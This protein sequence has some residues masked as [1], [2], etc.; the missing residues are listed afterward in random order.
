MLAELAAD[1]EIGR[2]L[3]RRPKLNP[4]GAW[5]RLASGLKTAAGELMAHGTRIGF[6]VPSR[7][8]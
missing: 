3:A 7:R 6:P 5:L 2:R 4:I 1:D 8:L